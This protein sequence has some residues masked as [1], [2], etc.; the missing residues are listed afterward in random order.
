MQLLT[1]NMI[2]KYNNNAFYWEWIKNSI[3]HFTGHACDYLSN[4][5][6]DPGCVY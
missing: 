3:S 4:N 5:F 6:N 1:Q 2:I